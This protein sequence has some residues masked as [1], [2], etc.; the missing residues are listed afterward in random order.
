MKVLLGS[1]YFLFLAA[2]GALNPYLALLLQERGASTQATAAVLAIF[3]IGLLLGSPL[4]TWLADKTGRPTPILRAAVAVAAIA[5]WAL[6]PART[7]W[8]FA[9][10]CL[11]MALCRAPASAVV[12][13]RTAALLTRRQDYGPIRLWGSV[14]FV[15]FCTG[16]G[17]V[18]DAHP[19]APL[20]A[21][22]AAVAL[23]FAVTLRLPA[24]APEGHAPLQRPSWGSLRKTPLLP[25]V[26]GVGLLH[27]V[28]VASYD[29]FF[30]LHVS[31]L[32]L[33]SRV[34]GLG[35]GLG[36]GV[37]IGLMA[38]APRLLHHFGARNLILLG[39]AASLPRW[40]LTGTVESEWLLIGIQSLHGFCFG[41][42]WLGS[43][44]LIA[45]HAP[46]HLRNSAQGLFLAA[47]HGVGSLL[48]MGL[49]AAILE[50]L[51]TA[52]LFKLLMIPSTAA[53]VLA[54]RGLRDPKDAQAGPPPETGPEPERTPKSGRP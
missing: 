8:I 7:W 54:L 19:D 13:M 15:V 9:P 23:L 11:A 53:L 14:G 1:W 31:Q 51:G 20:W 50:P 41:T 49:A 26:C 24:P 21:S 10:F 28:G 47:S 29:H 22:A 17:L 42:W 39:V 2:I 40:W 32:G 16:V 33:P 30:A 25:L 4:G 34:A 52:G 36:V 5:T 37:E 27:H 48:A 43:V 18:R 44:D 3:P 12:D 6:V 46:S 35:F 38:V 45:Q